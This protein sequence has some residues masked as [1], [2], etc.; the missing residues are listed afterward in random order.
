MPTTDLHQLFDQYGVPYYVKCDLE[1]ADELFRDQLER[2]NR[3]PTFVSLEVNSEIDIEVLG[4]AGY[5]RA[6]IVNQ[7]MH[8][9]TKAPHPPTEGS[10]FERQFTGE[11]SGLFGLELPREKWRSVYEIRDVYLRWRELKA[12]DENLA[13]GWVDIHVCKADTL[14]NGRR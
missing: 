13:P 10:Y 12:R 2:D 7:W 3:R 1:G 6:Q 9:F 14:N 11:M 5:D 8:P 4:K